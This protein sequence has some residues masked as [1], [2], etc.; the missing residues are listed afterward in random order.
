MLAPG[1][2]LRRRLE[3]WGEPARLDGRHVVLTG[4]TSG[5]GRAAAFAFVGLGARLTVVARSPQRAEALRTELGALYTARQGQ[6]AVEIADLADLGAV[7]STGR[8]IA[9]RGEQV[10][11]LVHNAGALSRRYSVG[12]SGIEQTVASQVIAVWLL[13]KLLRPVLGRSGGGSPG[14]GHVRARVITMTSGGL[15]TVRHDLAELEVGPGGYEG[16]TAYARAKRAQVVLTYGWAAEVGLA[17]AAQST[18]AFHLVDP[19]WVATGG[20]TDGMPLF[21]RL[22]APALRTPAEGA[23]TAVWL[24]GSAE[25]ATCSGRLWRDRRQRPIDRRRSTVLSEAE[26][27][28]A[29]RALEQWCAAKAASVGLAPDSDSVV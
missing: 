1:I 21:S 25:G 19:G 9:E 20:L 11:V 22:M 2:R 29:S 16:R 28:R 27:A 13:T 3:H 10:D 18:P 4:A 5:I 14:P 26:L 15:Y 7:A 17:G 12:P 23:D 6:I 8:A 24:A